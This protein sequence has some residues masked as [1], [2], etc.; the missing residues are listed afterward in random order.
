M[1]RD[2]TINEETKY[3]DQLSIN[4]IKSKLERDFRNQDSLKKQQKK[5]DQIKDKE[6]KEQL[7]IKENKLYKKTK[8]K[9]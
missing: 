4:K 6:N 8:I 1:E 7:K 2:K 5:Q 3:L 9:S